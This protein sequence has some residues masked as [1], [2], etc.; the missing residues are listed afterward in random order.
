M[1]YL[2]LSKDQAK[3]LLAE[4]EAATLEAF[5]RGC[6][7]GRAMAN[8]GLASTAEDDAY[9]QGYDDGNAEGYDQGYNDGASDSYD[10]GYE[11]GR[12]EAELRAAESAAFDEPPRIHEWTEGTRFVD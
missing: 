11:D 6:A 8:N 3:A 12:A 10:D 7:V 1:Q 9:D 5:D 4:V 2:I